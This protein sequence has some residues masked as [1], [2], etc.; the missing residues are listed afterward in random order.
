MAAF[1]LRRIL[2]SLVLVWI[3]LTITF[4]LLHLALD[5]QG[6][7]VVGDIQVIRIDARDGGFHQEGILVLQHVQRQGPL[8]VVHAEALRA[9][10]RAEQVLRE[11]EAVAA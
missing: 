1:L 7:S 4:F 9:R 11:N 8:D 6:V 3:V 2:Q 10:D 5:G